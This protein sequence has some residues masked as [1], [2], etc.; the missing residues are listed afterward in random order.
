MTKFSS[1]KIL[2]VIDSY[3][4]AYLTGMNLNA[5]TEFDKGYLDALQ[6]LHI[7]FEQFHSLE[8]FPDKKFFDK[9]AHRDDLEF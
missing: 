8:D 4:Q 9:I 6:A 3:E 7:Y 1:Y 5:P 2:G